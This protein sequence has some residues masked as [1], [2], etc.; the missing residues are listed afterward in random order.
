MKLII[1][2]GGSRGLG[3]EL[4]KLYEKSSWVVYEFSRSAPHRNSIQVDLSDPDAAHAVFL[5][6]FA[7][8]AQHDWDE[9]Q[10]LGNAATLHP[11]QP[12]ARMQ[13]H[14]LVANTHVNIASALLFLAAAVNAFQGHACRKL[15]VNISSG[16]ATK[17]Y[18]GWSLYCGAKAALEN[19]IRS[20]ALEQQQLPHP[21]TALSINPGLID[22][23][24]QAAIRA[25]SADNFPDVQK[26]HK[27][28]ADG[29][30]R[31]PAQVAA[32]VAHIL[33]QPELAPGEVYKVDE[34]IG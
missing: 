33:S 24:M 10:I 34:F 18:A 22:T 30:L 1:L 21:F 5:R 17:G 28:Q 4:Y 2:S 7:E 8:L 32:A 26:F 29:L 23:D 12:L 15:L 6:Q 11:M 13:P 14:D 20:V 27:R 25:T 3:S 19:V 16:A 31:P 9:I